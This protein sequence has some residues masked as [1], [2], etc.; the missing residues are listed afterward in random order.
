MDAISRFPKIRKKH[1]KHPTAFKREVVL[2]TLKPGA[3]VSIVA[4]RYDLNANQVFSWRKAYRE[5]GYGELDGVKLLPVTV[6][7][8]GEEG[9]GKDEVESWCAGR[10][11]L[12]GEGMTLRIEGCPDSDTLRLIL[13]HWR[14]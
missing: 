8:S 11:E 3:S 7:T 1:R 10:I 14:R 4:R 9:A 2:E 13:T 12:S 5:R 6:S